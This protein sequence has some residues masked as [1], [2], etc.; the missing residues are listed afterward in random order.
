[1]SILLSMVV[2][3][4]Y[5][6]FRFIGED[7]YEHVLC[8]S[9][10]FLNARVRRATTIDCDGGNEPINNWRTASKGHG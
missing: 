8:S 7:S 6:I 3:E 4:E 1:M 10:S 9:G 5:T 2:S